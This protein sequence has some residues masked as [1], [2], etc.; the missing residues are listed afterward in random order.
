M[1]FR[2]GVHDFQI[3]R[4]SANYTHL[5]VESVVSKHC[6]VLCVSLWSKPCDR[7]G[8][9]RDSVK[10]VRLLAAYMLLA[11][12]NKI[13]KSEFRRQKQ[14]TLMTPAA[15]NEVCLPLSRNKAA[16]GSSNARFS[17]LLAYPPS[18]HSDFISS[19]SWTASAVEFKNSETLEVEL[20]LT[21]FCEPVLTCFSCLSCLWL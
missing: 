15:S 18:S 3:A 21:S 9:F 20:G 7:P 10:L 8:I 6:V 11:T 2:G 5:I 16:K 4:K 12:R 13:C 14:L 17:V 1:G 19:T